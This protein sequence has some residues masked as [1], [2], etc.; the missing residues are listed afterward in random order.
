MNYKLNHLCCQG[1]FV[2]DL[3]YWVTE[4]DVGHPPSADAPHTSCFK[5]VIL[6]IAH[7][8]HYAGTA[9][10]LLEIRV[11]LFVNILESCSL[12]GALG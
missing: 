1:L 7:E 11:A 2:T 8:A 12:V 4:D 5:L 3:G 10:Q 6:Y 9:H